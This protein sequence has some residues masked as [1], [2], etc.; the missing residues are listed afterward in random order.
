MNTGQY[1]SGALHIGLIGWVLVGNVFRSEPPEPIVTD[2]SVISTAEFEA[3]LASETPPDAMTEMQNLSFQAAEEQVV[4]QE[5]TQDEAPDFQELENPEPPVEDE[6]PEFEDVQPVQV[7][8]LLTDIPEMSVPSFQTGPDIKIDDSEEAKPRDADR[9]A[10]VPFLRPELDVAVSQEVTEAAAEREVADEVVEEQQEDAAPE[11]ATTEIVTEAE[12]PSGAP[13]AVPIPRLRP[14]RTASEE[15]TQP[16]QAQ[17]SATEAALFEAL[18]SDDAPVE[19]QEISAG[20]SLS[21][22]EIS[23]LVR[24]IGECWSLGAASTSS[25][26]VSIDVRVEMEQ[27][28][29]PKDS[30]ELI[31]YQGGSKEAAEKAFEIARRAI[32]RCSIQNNGYGLPPDKYEQWKVIIMTFDP[33]TMRTK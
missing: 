19:E 22:S 11:E 18:S 17:Q 25:L 28:S 2:V 26:S 14:Q 6:S 13:G 12:K 27:T 7:Q 20:P 24:K 3:L 4:E 33:E 8:D 5:Q 1:I 30:I 29:K 23:N 21:A 15:T 9:V 16:Q 32:L 31:S 10:P